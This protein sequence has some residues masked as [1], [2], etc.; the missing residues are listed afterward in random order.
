MVRCTSRYNLRKLLEKN[1]E[2]FKFEI[3]ND[4]YLSNE[5]HLYWDLK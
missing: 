4:F 5:S 3:W 2:R 1:G